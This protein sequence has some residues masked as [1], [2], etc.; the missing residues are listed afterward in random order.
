MSASGKSV[1]SGD[2]YMDE[3][4]YMRVLMTNTGGVWFTFLI[5]K[6]E[7]SI[8]HAWVSEPKA[9]AFIPDNSKYVMNIKDMLI[10]VRQELLSEPSN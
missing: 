8:A 10:S 5:S 2:V 1:K 6:P 3:D 9:K 4:G 7:S